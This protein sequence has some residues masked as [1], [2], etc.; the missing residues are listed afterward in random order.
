MQQRVLASHRIQ[1]I[2]ANF[3]AKL[4]A[5][6]E[7]DHLFDLPFELITKI[8]VKLMETKCTSLRREEVEMKVL[9]VPALDMYLA[10]RPRKV[11]LTAFL[12]FCPKRLKYQY[13]KESLIHISEKAADLEELTLVA[14]K[15][16]SARFFHGTADAELLQL[17]GKLKH[18]KV[19]RIEEIVNIRL[20]DLIQLCQ[21]LP[22]LEYLHFMIYNELRRL[23]FKKLKIAEKLKSAMPKLQVFLFDTIGSENALIKC[24]MD[25]LPNL[26]VIHDFSSVFGSIEDYESSNE[27]TRPLGSS[28]LRHLL[29][30]FDV[31]DCAH[32]PSTFPLITHLR[33]LL[34]PFA[35]TKEQNLTALLQLT[36]L[37]SLELINLPQDILHLFVVKFGPNLREISVEYDDE[38]DSVSIDYSLGQ[39]LALCPKL[40]RLAFAANFKEDLKPI[41]FFS[42]LKEI[43]MDFWDFYGNEHIRLTDILRAPNLEK[44]TF[45]GSGLDFEELRR[46]ST[47]IKEKKILRNLKKLHFVTNFNS[48]EY[49]E[50]DYFK[51]VAAFI[52]CVAA[53]L[54]T[55][56][57]ITFDL[58]YRRFGYAAL[59]RTLTNGIRTNDE[60]DGI[61]EF[62]ENQNISS[63][64]EELFVDE[65]LIAILEKYR[66]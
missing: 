58:H 16:L 10:M 39:L 51:E 29:V 64:F 60:I 54:P 5:D 40:E 23:D 61:T 11:D 37:E 46:V 33:I 50:E 22:D 62:F 6:F 32:L 45:N 27:S 57:V 55:I 8:V 31:K 19:L 56:S 43:R 47:L 9:M 26:R 44:I 15:I 25:N 52:K 7:L 24:C 30:D 28:N 17:L 13:L 49:F 12:T 38:C 41:A 20:I 4:S 2:A 36:H 1:G 63:E 14:P 21:N 66:C 48:I 3:G 42:H 59:A 18:L 35:D 65:E 53:S 34:V